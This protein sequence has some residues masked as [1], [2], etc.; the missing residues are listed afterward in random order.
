ASE[1]AINTRTSM[2]TPTVP[3]RRKT[4]AGRR[5]LMHLL[6]LIAMEP[7]FRTLIWFLVFLL[8]V[9]VRWKALWGAASR[10]QYLV[11][12]LAAADQARRQGV[13]AISVIEFGVERGDGLRA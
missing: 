8:P 6:K 5:P 12:I 13:S 11:G 4:D 3:V 7:P 9:R 10:A 1:T 2:S